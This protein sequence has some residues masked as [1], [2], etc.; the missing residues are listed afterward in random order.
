MCLEENDWFTDEA[1]RLLEKDIWKARNF[2]ITAK[3]LCP[4]NLKLKVSL[5]VNFLD[6][7]ILLLLYQTS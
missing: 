1:K 2:I 5:L 6:F 4:N 3:T 7:K